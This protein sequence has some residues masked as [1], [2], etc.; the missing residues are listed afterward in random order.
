MGS[1][2]AGYLHADLT[3]AIIGAA[4]E[5]HNKLG[6]GFLESVYE[7]ALAWELE[8]LGLTVHRQHRLKVTYK[9]IVAGEFVADIVVNGTVVVEIKATSENH[10]IH[11]AQLL[12]YLKGTGMKVGLLLNFGQKRL[13]YKRFVF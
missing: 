4:F 10:D 9:E 1:E 7:T 2:S 5:V 6:P 8:K 11:E 13:Y 12:N 3:H